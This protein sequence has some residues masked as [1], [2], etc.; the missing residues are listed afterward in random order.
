MNQST[1]SEE[2]CVMLETLFDHQLKGHDCIFSQ[3][4][5]NDESV[6]KPIL[7][8]AERIIE[9]FYPQQKNLT[10]VCE[11][12]YANINSDIK[13]LHNIFEW[14][15]DDNGPFM[16]NIFAI[17]F[18]LRKDCNGGNLLYRSQ[19]CEVKQIEIK[20]GT[21]LTFRGNLLHCPQDMWGVWG[22]KIDSLFF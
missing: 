17:L 21:I 15:E 8:E 19:N 2:K 22:T 1:L 5:I 7:K 9:Q 10:N 12:H 4:Q 14:H 18:Y 16:G 11:L 20:R 13:I 3:E 6:R